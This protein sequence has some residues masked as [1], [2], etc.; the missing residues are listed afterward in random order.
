MTEHITFFRIKLLFRTMECCVWLAFYTNGMFCFQFLVFSI[1]FLFLFIF[2]V[3][4][5]ILS[6]SHFLYFLFFSFCCLF[7]CSSTQMIIKRLICL[8]KPTSI[9]LDILV[10]PNYVFERP[11]FLK[12]K[13]LH[14]SIYNTVNILESD[15]LRFGLDPPVIGPTN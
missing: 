6:F 15:I 8:S 13:N 14:P 10:T 9:S 4:S 1:F 5:S 7:M 3:F 11:I 2:F 12:K